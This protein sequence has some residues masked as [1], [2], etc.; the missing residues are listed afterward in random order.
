MTRAHRQSSAALAAGLLFGVG[1]VVSGMTV[2]AKV[3][4]F[5]DFAG[6]WD[7]TLMFVMAGAIAVHAVVYRLVRRRASPLFA[8]AFQVPTRKD[9]D[10]RL[11]LGAAIFGVGWGLGGYCPG[12][13]VSSLVTGSLSPLAFVAAMLG[14]MW[15]VGRLDRRA[16]RPEGPKRATRR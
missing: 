12:P 15:A 14:A 1:L 6:A 13:A 11:V 9:I 3:I 8:D 2:P 4:G 5:L 16:R 7:P 10:A